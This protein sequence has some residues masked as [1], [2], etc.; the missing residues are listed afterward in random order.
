MLEN[1]SGTADTT[2]MGW[3]G[4]TAYDANRVKIGTITAHNMQ[5]G[6]FVAQKGI[7]F[8]HDVYIPVDAVTSTD[9][10][11]VYLN[12]TNDQLGDEC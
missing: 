1:Q 9:A 4:M 11:G 8:P 6:Y 7:F 10:S 2:N 3:V 5:A 12:L